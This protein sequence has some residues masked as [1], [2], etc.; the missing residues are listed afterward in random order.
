MAR[1]TVQ[2]HI[3]MYRPCT[4]LRGSAGRKQ[5]VFTALASPQN[6]CQFEGKLFK[7]VYVFLALLIM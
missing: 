6:M 4:Q 5:V 3:S 1:Y 7:E 2:R